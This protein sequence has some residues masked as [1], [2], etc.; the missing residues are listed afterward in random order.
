MSATI[1]THHLNAVTTVLYQH[2]GWIIYPPPSN[3]TTLSELQKMLLH[4]TENAETGVVGV[5]NIESGR[6]R[7][8]FFPRVKA[9]RHIS[10][11][12]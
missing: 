4:G 9:E 10:V 11:Q 6:Q 2:E 12:C 3:S 1:I 5:W 8:I 7:H